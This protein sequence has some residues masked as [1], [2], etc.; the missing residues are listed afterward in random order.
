MSEAQLQ[1]DNLARGYI[2][3]TPPA[4]NPSNWANYWAAT[5]DPAPAGPGCG[6]GGG[7][8]CTLPTDPGT[9]NTVSYTIQRL[10]R[11]AG[12]PKDLLTGC[13]SHKPSPSQV[14]NCQTMNCAQFPPPTQYY[15]RITTRVV[16]PRNTVSYIQ[17]IVRR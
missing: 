7:R 6:L 14:G 5:I 16:G 17:T 9:N 11:A 3:S 4:G 10:C 2:A 15:Y 12:D 1:N 8:A 13:A